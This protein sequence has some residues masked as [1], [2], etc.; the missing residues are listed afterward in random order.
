[1]KKKEFKLP[2][3]IIWSGI[4]PDD[5]SSMVKYKLWVNVLINF[6][7]FTL[8]L[9]AI[10]LLNDL[11]VPFFIFILILLI[12]VYSIVLIYSKSSSIKRKVM[13]TTVFLLLFAS[14]VLSAFHYFASLID[15]S[16]L[17]YQ[18]NR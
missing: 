2:S 5:G 13:V 17:F 9:A 1:M 3:E 7:L 11:L 10:G 14:F 16:G 8:S 15:L 12:T 18:I 6:F 4:K